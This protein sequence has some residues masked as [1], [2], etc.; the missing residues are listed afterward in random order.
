MTAHVPA[1]LVA[2]AEPTVVR[3]VDEV[4][5]RTGFEVLACADGAGVVASITHRKVEIALVDLHLPGIGGLDVLRLARDADPACQVVLMTERPS[6]DSAVEAVKLGAADVLAKPLDLSRLER[7]LGSVR[8]E[9]VRRHH[10]LELDNDAARRLEFCGL[11]GRSP[12]MQDLFALIRRLAPHVR[13][14]LVRGEPGTGKELAARALHTLGPRSHRPF[15]G[16]ACAGLEPITGEVELFGRAGPGGAGGQPGLFELANG[17]TVFL[18]DVAALSM[19]VQARL[20]RVLESGEVTRVGS[21]EEHDVDLHVI[22][23]TVRDLRQAVAAGRFRSD[24][25]YRLAVIELPLPPLRDRREDIPYLT[26]AFVRECAAALAKPIKGVTA[27]AESLLLSAA[28][29]GNVRELRTV[30]ERACLLAEGE[31]VTEREIAQ[32]MPAPGGTL[33]T[34]ASD[35][36]R[37]GDGGDQLLATVERAHILRAL[38]RSGGNKKAAARMLGVSRRALYRRLERL[39]LGATITRRPRRV[40]HAFERHAGA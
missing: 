40:V 12:Q 1:L 14:A 20:L 19:P 18:E 25:F 8:D 23:S 33:L 34:G 35:D 3:F 17:G 30:V 15:V 9:S 26:A 36:Q 22:A 7:L 29:D 10:L 38:Q 32:S 39:D 27:A 31:L 11:I 24:L 37:E 21:L 4:G 6:V 2:D 5:R 13:A 28:W 16:V